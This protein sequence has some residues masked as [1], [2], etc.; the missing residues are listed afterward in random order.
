[1]NF[2]A[3]GNITQVIDLPDTAFWIFFLFFVLLC[4]YNRRWDK[5]EGYPLK[6]S[7]FTSETLDGF[8]PMPADVETYKLNE[9]GTTDAPHFYEPGTTHGEPLYA[10]DGTPFSPLGNPLLS[11]LGPGAWVRKKDEPALT[12]GGTLLLQPMRN[13]PEWSIAKRDA[14][15]RGMAVF[16]WRWNRVGTV[17]DIWIDHGI[18][19]VRIFEVALLPEFGGGIVLVPIYFCVI[20]ERRREIRVVALRSTQFAEIPRPAQDDRIT[21]QED[22]RLNAYFAAGKF[23]RDSP[24][25]APTRETVWGINR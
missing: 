17:R 3:F 24:L 15:P 4:L 11:G 2:G 16:D 13:L 21:G 19:I 9:G 23:Y 8:P 1:M 12:E 7:P 5:R 18:K 25:T 20:K 22:E 6:A 14:D 10:F